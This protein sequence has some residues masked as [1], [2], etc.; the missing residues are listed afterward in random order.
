MLEFPIF[1]Y[2]GNK[3]RYDT[4]LMKLNQ[5]LICCNL[6]GFVTVLWSQNVKLVLMLFACLFW[7]PENISIQ[8]TVPYLGTFLTDLMM[9]DSALKDTAE[10]NGELINFD[11]RRKEFEVLMQI[12][13][14]QASAA[15]YRIERD[16]DFWLKFYNIHVNTDNER[17][18]S[19]DLLY[20]CC[21]FTLMFSI[22][23]WYSLSK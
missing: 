20:S 5:Q 1:G 10:D 21:N 13:L 23:K 3:G 14:L 15:L 19:L 18:C 11:K 6:V 12:R 8:G 22:Y 17:F 7:K 16:D 4:I 2:S 9:I